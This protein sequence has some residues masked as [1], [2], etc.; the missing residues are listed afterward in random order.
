MFIT[1]EACEHTN[2][3]QH[4]LPEALLFTF[5]YTQLPVPY[6]LASNG[7]AIIIVCQFSVCV[8]YLTTRVLLML[9][10]LHLFL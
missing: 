10:V 1:Y 5:V 7:T 2:A 9:Q 4:L 6:D 3:S 8:Q